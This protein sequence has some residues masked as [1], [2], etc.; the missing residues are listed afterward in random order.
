MY[1]CIRKTL[2]FDIY[3]FGI[4]EQKKIAVYVA[5]VRFLSGCIR[6]RCG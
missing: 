1:N 4:I 6:I 3:D 2:F 5:A